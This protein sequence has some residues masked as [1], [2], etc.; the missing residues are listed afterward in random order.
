MSERNLDRDAADGFDD[1]EP[2][3][4]AFDFGS[5]DNALAPEAEQQQSAGV[6]P[7]AINPVVIPDGTTI[8]RLEVEG[9][10]LIIVLAD[11]NRIVVPDGAINVPQIIAQGAVIP[12][13]NVAALLIGNEAEPAAGAPQ[14]SGGNFLVDPRDLQDAFDLGDLLPYTELSRLLVQE[15]EVIPAPL[16]DDEPEVVIETPDNPVGVENAIATVLEEGLPARGEPSEPEGTDEA[17]SGETT[18]GTIVFSSPDGVSAILINDVEI[19]AVGQTFTSPYGTLTITSINLASGEIGFS[20]TLEDNSLGVEAD[21]FFV[22][23]IV[24]TDGDEASATLQINIVDDGPIGV[25]DS[26]TVPGGSH[27]PI[28]GNVLA[29]DISGA[30]DFPVGEGVTGFSNAG[31]SAAPGETLVGTYGELTI[32]ED[33]SYTYVRNLDSGGGVEEDFTYEIVDQDGSVSSAVLTIS[34]EDAPPG[35]TFIPETGEGTLVAEGGL[36]PRGD[37]PVGTGEGADAVP[38]NNSDSSEETSA[39]V[40]FSSPD[41]LGGITIDGVELDI[42]NLPQTIVSDDT[43]TLV[44]T[45][46]VFDPATGLGSFTYVYTL[47]DNTSGDDTSVSFEIVVRDLDGDTDA[48]DLVIDIQDD[49]PEAADDFGPEDVVEDAPITVNVIDNDVVGA[50]DVQDDDIALVEGSLQGAG[51]VVYN[52]DGTF[53]YTPVPGEEGT[54]TFDY[55]IT[56]TDG[57]ESTATV[58][59]VLADDSTPTV[60]V[61]DGEVDEA[62]LGSGS[63]PSSDAESDTGTFTITTGNDTLAATGGLV[64]EDKDGNLVDVT[65]GGVVQGTYGVL[66]VSENAGVYSWSYTLSGNTTD[67]PDDTSTGTA[68][69]ITDSFNVTVTDSDG[70]SAGDVLDVAVLDDGPTAAD[71]A[72]TQS[73]ENA[74]I[75]GDVKADNGNGVDVEGA[76]QAGVYAYNG[77]IANGM[78][79][80]TGTLDFDPDGTFTYTP[81]TGEEGTITFTYTLTDTDGDE[82][83][84]T[85]TIVLADDS[86]PT[87]TVTDG[88]VD[89]AALGSGSDPSSDAESDTGTFTITTGNDTLAATGGLVIEDK[90]GNLVDVTAGGVVQGTYGVLTVSENAGVYSWSYT[91]SGNTT[92]HPD[93]TSTGTAEGI[94]DSFNVTVTDSD[95]D[96]AGDVLDVAV[97]DDGPTAADDALTQSPEN[98]PIVGDVKAD[99]GN[100]VDVEGADQAGVYAYNGDIA[101]GMA[102]ATGTLDFDPDGTFTYT[103]GTGEEGTITF[104]YTLTDTDGDESTATVTIVLADDSTPTVTVTDGEV[105]EAALGSGSDPSSD[106]ESDTGTFTITTGND[107]LAATGGLVIEDKDGNLVD[108]TAGGV[109]QGT[110]GVL[111]VSENAGVYSWSYTL[112]GNTTDHPDDTSTGTAEGIT[113]SFNVTVTDSDGD[114][115]GDVLDVAVLDDGPTAADDALTQSPENA[116]IVGDVK[117]DNGNGVDVEG[118]DQA[119]VYAYNGDIANGMA[120]ATGTLDFDPDGTFTYTPGTGEEGTITFTYTLTDTDG[121]ESTATVTIVLADDSTPTVTVTDGEVDEA[122]LGSGSDPSSD[123]ESD[124]G[125]FTITTGNDTLAATGGLV[126]EDKD[127]NLVDVTAGGVVQGTYGVLTVSENAGVYSW[128]YT[129]SGNTTDHPD[130]T[131]TGTAEGITDSFNVTVTDSDGDSAGDVLDVAVLDDGPTAADDAL[132]QSPENAPIVGDVKA[133]NGNGVDVEGADQAGVYAYNGD[134]ANGMAAATGTLD[135]D[136]DGTFTY[137]PGTGEEGTITFTYTLT[138]TDGDESTATVTIVLADDSTPTVTV[139]DGEVDEAALGS[140]SDP[141]SDA[142]SDTGTFT[143]TTGNDT[144]AATGGL[145]IEDKDGN[146][147]DVTA[148]GVV[149]GTYG[150]LTVSENAGVYSWSYTL[151]GNTTDHPDDTSTGTAEGITDSFNVTVTDSDGDSAGD[152]LDVAVLD[153]G[154]TAADDALTQSPENAP[155]VGDVKADNGNGVD[156]EGADQAGVYAYNGDIANGMAAATGTLDFDP[157]GTFTY[158]PGTGEEGTI[159]FTYTLT[160]TDGDESTA[161]VTIVLAD[162]STPTVTVTDGEVDEAALG[163]GSDPS[164]DAESDTG[165]FTITTG[166]DTLAATGGLVIEDKDGNLVDVTAGGVVQGTYGVLTVSE[167]AG[168]YSW[169]YTLS[170]NTTDHPDDT[171]TGTA[172]GITDS[173]NVTVTDS[174]GDSAGDV[175]DVAVLDDGPTAADDALTQSPENAPIVGDV[176]ADNGNGVDVEGADQAG[177]YAYNGDIANGMAAATGTLDFD[178]DGTFTYTPGTGEEGTITFTYTLTDTDGDESTATVTIVL[179]DDSTPTVT[180]TDGEVDE[181]ALGSGSDPSSDAE[182][183]T[184]TF[185]I[186]T[187]NDTLAATGGLV[188]E[189]K[190]GNL[191]DVTAG[192][193]VQGTYG[194]LTVSE[195][196]GVY[197][198]SYTLSGNTTDHPDDTSTGT[199]EGITDSFNVTVTDSDGDSAGDVLD[200]AVLDDGPTAA[201]DALTQSPENAPIV[202]DVKADNGNGVDV[203]GADQAGVYAYNGDIANGMAAATGTLDFDPD[204]TFTYTPGTGEEGTITFTYTLTDTDGDESTATVTIVLA[205]DS[206]PTVTVTDGEVDEAALGSGSDPSSDAESDTGTFTITTGNDTLAATGGL[207]I[208]DKDGNLVDVTAGGVVQ[209]TYGVLTVSENAG[210]YSWSYT[211][212]GN[213]TD[214]PDDTSTGT[215]E[216]ITDSFNVTVTDSDGDSAGDVL[217]VAVL[218]DGP[219]AADDALTQSPENAPI[220]GD[221][222]A[223]NGNGVDV[224]GADQAGVYAYNGDI[225]NGMAAATGTLDFDPDGT[226]TYTPGTG[227]EGTITFTYTLTDTDGDESTATVTI[228][229]ADD[230]TPTVTVTDGEVDEAALGS[231]SDPSSDAESDT[232]TFTITTGNDTLAATGGL[233]IEDKDGNLVD[234]TAGG[235]VQ[236]TYGVLTVSENAGVY[237]WSYT[238]SG[239][240]TDHPDDTSTG[241]AEGITDS[242]NVT[243]TDSDGDSAGDVLDVAVLDDGPDVIV[244]ASGATVDLD[245]TQNTSLVSFIDTG[246]IAKGDDP[247][248]G[249]TGAISVDS[250]NSSII[251]WVAVPGADGN[252]GLTF[253]LTVLNAASGLSV[254]DGSPINLELLD[255]GVVVGVVQGGVYD[256]QAAFAISLNP[257]TGIV[258]TEQYL[259]LNHPDASDPDDVIDLDD[260]TLGV[261]ATIVDGD[262][263]TATSAPAD[264]S[265]NINFS[266][267]GPTAV[268]ADALT[269]TNLAATYVADLDSDDNVDNNFGADGGRVIF[270]QATITSLESQGLTSGLV[271]LEYA[272]SSDGTQ[273]FATKSGSGDPVFTITLDPDGVNEDQYVLELDAPI[274]A[275]Q[276]IDFNG[277]GYNFVGGNGSWAGFNQPGTANSQDV[278]LTPTQGNNVDSS[279]VNTNAN[280]GGIGSGNSVGSGEAMRVDFVIDLSGTPKNG[281]DYAIPANQDHSFTGHYDVNGASAL[282]TAISGNPPTSTVELRAYDDTDNDNDVGDGAPVDISAVVIEFNGDSQVITTAGVHTVGGQNFTVAFNGDSATVSG[283]VSDTRIGGISDTPYNSI[284]FHWAGGQTF[285]IGDFNTIAITNDPVTFNVPIS[286]IDNDDDVVSSGTL[287]ITLNPSVTPIVL[288]LDGGGN[289]YSS[290]DAGIAYDYNGDGAKTQTAWIAAG[291]AILA[292]DANGD[293]YVTDASEFVFGG[294]GQTDL[295][296]VAARFDTDGDGMLTQADDAFESFGIWLDSDLDAEHDAGEFVSLSDAGISSIELVSNNLISVEADGDVVEFGTASFTMSD[297]TTGAV[298]DAAFATG[299]EI[300]MASMD[301]LLQLAEQNA[302]STQDLPV[303]AVKAEILADIGSEDE[304]EALIDQF[305]PNSLSEDSAPIMAGGEAAIAPGGAEELLSGSLMQFASFSELAPHN[306][307]TLDEGM[308]NVVA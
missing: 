242:F 114:S 269:G 127:G 47:A 14:S 147:V 151:S 153:D 250:S 192:G 246:T 101:N 95:G 120:A 300:D 129:L 194:V 96:S 173:F 222:K 274:D 40:T 91:L 31:G 201:D 64:I 159:T 306:N 247:D 207:V 100:G 136:P 45:D 271:D 112:S 208:E 150:V 110:Y 297:G 292:F 174:D 307:N 133:D 89:E 104:T 143:I 43:G 196:A 142:E 277:G 72:L 200:V 202:G 146:L 20:Y 131:S 83:T 259:S 102:A 118:A 55:S 54:V 278:L 124:T 301:A 70:D 119:G 11:G 206:T 73:P 26:A 5:D 227:E 38:D 252:S 257:T 209:G 10:D 230:S 97:L 141:S 137:T 108:V 236:G 36:P 49:E 264:I 128:S 185:T 4:M 263:D 268:V 82:S 163:S 42:D 251:S 68:E 254:T 215:A 145:V 172:E 74:P 237:S 85:V 260:G 106:A 298:S 139:T 60:T 289:A 216:G 218:D 86:T 243:V 293:G 256:G 211:L 165:T 9:D 238:L 244:N 52:G 182:S 149:Q 203:E 92:D 44:I 98:A 193:V 78:A 161:T 258:T 197:S 59:I 33:G 221:V 154:P 228:V 235:V 186:T 155:I 253:G 15:E 284:E 135:F 1:V 113:D 291:S 41:G 7:Q 219:T 61:T 184:G 214:H 273:I 84:A 57:D 56:D 138:D 67:H 189:D 170:G 166:N 24:D 152:V 283:V 262:G 181:A 158:T 51:S 6:G 285:K 94:T 79:A 148:G 178:P 23:T 198:W 134:I 39:T 282:F 37:E 63:D 241:T 121:D 25:D 204:G 90:D 229:L 75:V 168:V 190:D 93:D 50:D 231:G 88:E 32:N 296:A 122:A 210:V 217:D 167:N 103:P 261:V 162:D 8:E 308:V 179:A 66:T 275:L 77:D 288:D 279:T 171:S 199:A 303:T 48:G 18:A 140:G 76:D 191:V 287:D 105:D 109:V 169:S 188:I 180:V 3:E 34:I 195:N 35:I 233:V 187:G 265:A 65:A 305:A 266:D 255:S 302:A 58:T 272:L 27:D 183:D 294:N 213:T 225:A 177:V 12:P 270:T 156:V 130:D 267:D 234:V 248:V 71:D 99:N 80:A 132:T 16:D 281:A 299:S 160:D 28:S 116:P 62:A 87:V 205:D 13:Q 226:F 115:A 295:E 46:L 157:D 223:D 30:D 126:I 17:G 290:L 240:T 22:A 286:V 176:K 21:G 175:L 304:L 249:G 212:S 276:T 125:T 164:S 29:N 107:T 220:V 123:A 69:G 239:N 224:E 53:T 19:T 144:L 2:A 117:A 111:T 81:G 232:G 245:E 280:E